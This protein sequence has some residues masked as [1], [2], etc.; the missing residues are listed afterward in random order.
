LNQGKV[1]AEG[2][3]EDFRFSRSGHGKI[4]YNFF[5]RSGYLEKSKGAA[6]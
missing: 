4:L 1:M 6:I 2:A 3:Q 5:R